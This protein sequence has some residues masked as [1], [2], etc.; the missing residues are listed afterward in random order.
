M[1]SRVFHLKSPYP[2]TW[3]IVATTFKVALFLVVVIFVSKTLLARFSSADLR[4]LTIRPPLFI[5]GIVC[6]FVSKLITVPVY[7]FT[8]QAFHAKV[9]G[10][11]LPAIAWLPPLGKYIPGKLTSLLGVLWL[12]DKA[13]IRASLASA[14]L[15]VIRFFSL[16][17]AFILACPAVFLLFRTGHVALMWGIGLLVA[18][19]GVV[20]LHPPI[21]DWYANG[22]LR[23]IGRPPLEK[24]PAIKEYSLT[25]IT[26]GIQWISTGAAFWCIAASLT[27]LPGTTL[28]LSISASALANILGYMA[29]FAPAGLGVREGVFLLC[30]ESII[31]GNSLVITILLLRIIQILTE[32]ILAGLGALLYL[33]FLPRKAS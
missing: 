29:F 11:E 14:V 12:F 25:A 9:R 23:R 31:P 6:V 24:I 8:L 32:I 30:M 19:A 22:F 4:D 16:G 17:I 2:R 13:G 5:L 7:H 21:F 10:K 3:R 33:P 20:L 15:F 27:P 18:C 28:P 26:I 1:N